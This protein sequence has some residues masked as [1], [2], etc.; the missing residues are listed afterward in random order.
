MTADHILIDELRLVVPGLDADSARCL[1]EEVMRRV[2][3]S[4]PNTSLP[5]FLGS[6]DI[7]VRIPAEATPD[8]WA[9]RIAQRIGEALR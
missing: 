5:I 4:I 1:G 8:V 9:E 3:R 2:A 6:L 7:R